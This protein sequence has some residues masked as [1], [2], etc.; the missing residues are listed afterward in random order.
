MQT[1]MSARK[2]TLLFFRPTGTATIFISDYE[3]RANLETIV[4]FDGNTTPS[5]LINFANVPLNNG[6]SYLKS[7]YTY[8]SPI[9]YVFDNHLIKI[10]DTDLKRERIVITGRLDELAPVTTNIGR[11]LV[12]QDLLRGVESGVSPDR[13]RGAA[14]QRPPP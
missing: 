2:S 9:G 5:V 12:N 6:D 11:N 4:F 3:A 14:A 10:N 7:Y 1:E 8:F 13:G